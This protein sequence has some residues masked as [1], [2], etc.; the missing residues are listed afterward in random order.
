MPMTQLELLLARLANAHNMPV[1]E[2]APPMSLGPLSTETTAAYAA[3]NPEPV[4]P[5]FAQPAPVDTNFVN[6]YAGQQPT[7]PAP[8]SRA[9]RILSAIGGFGAGVEGRGAEYLYA[10]GE[11]QRRYESQ[12]AQFEERRTR[13]IEIAERRAE[14]EAEL[15]NRANELSYER[16]FKVWLSKNNDRSD[17]AKQ[18]MAQ[19]FTL[20]RD[21]NAARLEEEREQR[22]ERARRLDDAR[23]IAG[24]LGTGPGAAPAAIA[25][26]LGLYYANATDSLSPAA[27]KFVNAQA[28]R[29]RILASRGTGGGG[30]SRASNAAL[31]AAAE[32][33]GARGE[34]IAFEQNRGRFTK[35]Q[36]ATEERRIQARINRAVGNT[37]RFPQQL[38]AGV[39]LNGWPYVKAWDGKQFVP[40]PGF[41]GQ[42]QQGAQPQAAP[43]PL[44]VR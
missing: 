33:E 35:E 16:D 39:D 37:K 10:L 24:R 22:R 28:Q 15:A 1:P 7:P 20:Q 9:E 44:G 36:Q 8:R 29:A 38:E 14:R 43:D 12:R 19:M 2:P 11:P 5:R 27:A 34:R 6:Q 42:Q 26:E 40:L 31:R 13:G 3:Q 21:A 30:T 4:P 25:K 18:R 32:V 17:E 41:G 23:A